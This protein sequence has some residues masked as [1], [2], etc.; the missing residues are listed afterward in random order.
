MYGRPQLLGSEQ[1][2]RR[3][4]LAAV[5]VASAVCSLGAD[6]AIADRSKLPDAEVFAANTTDVITD[7]A[8]PRLHVRLVRFGRT[9][10]R[11]I[12]D[13][14]G[15]P[16]GSQL[17]DGVFFSTL[18]GAT[19]FQRSRAFEVDSV[20]RVELRAIA[21]TVRRRFNQ[22]SVLTFDYRERRSDPIDAVE[23]EVPGV[24]A[25]R[26]REGFA[27]DKRARERL[28]GGSVTLDSRLILI[29]S[30]G[31]LRLA[32]RFAKKIGGKLGRATIRRGRREFVAPT[33]GPTLR[34]E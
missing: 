13:G 25:R 34:A 1:L 12:R 2:R 27:A 10:Q 29:A 18:L 11:I 23:V 17:L 32:K 15:R 14:G 20:S 31:D 9:V 19:T 8:D 21:D 3:A 6:S 4:G 5:L 28:L 24:S 22:Q 33:D 7:P 30:L 26:L 16:R